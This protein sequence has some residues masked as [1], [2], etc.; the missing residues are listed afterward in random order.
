MLDR[1]GSLIR[2]WF[3]GQETTLSIPTTA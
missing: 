2:T 3:D 1:F